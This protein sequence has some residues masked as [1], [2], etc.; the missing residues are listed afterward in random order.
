MRA[1]VWGTGIPG[2]VDVCRR[3]DTVVMGSHAGGS[4]GIIGPVRYSRMINS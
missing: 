2:R 3:V 1:R 4:N